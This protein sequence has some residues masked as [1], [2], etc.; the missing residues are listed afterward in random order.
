MWPDTPRRSGPPSVV[1]ILEPRGRRLLISGLLA[2]VPLVFL[3]VLV[4]RSTVDVPV[5]DEWEIVPRL[6]KLHNGT[7]SYLDLWGQHNEH[8]PLFGIALVM[9]LVS[10][11]HW[12]VGAE[13]AANLIVGAL[14][15]AVFAGVVAAAWPEDLRLPLWLLPA[16]SIFVFSPSQYENWLW[17]WQ[18]TILLNVLA[19]VAGLALLSRLDGRWIRLAGAL[20]CGIVATYTFAAGLV[21]WVSGLAVWV[22]DARKARKPA[23]IA[24]WIA[25][26]GLTI[27]SYFY[28]YHANP[29]HPRIEA[30][31]E[32]L[33]AFRLY[34]LYVVK[35]TG[36]AVALYSPDHV[37]LAG[38]A[39][40]VLFAWL[41]FVNRRLAGRPIFTF[42]ILVGLHCLGVAAMT[43]L[44][45]SGFGA[46]QG[47]ASRYV[48]ISTPLWLAVV[49][50]AA[51][52]LSPEG[53]RR[54]ASW[55]FDKVLVAAAAVAIGLSTLVNAQDGTRLSA[56]R[57]ERLEPAR[58]ALINGVG[59]QELVKLYPDVAEVRRRRGLLIE[60]HMSV[61]RSTRAQ[62]DSSTENR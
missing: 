40:V 30:N 44:G 61:F 15:F 13:I 56:E 43:G 60:W 39:A 33:E 28:D 18:V 45:R 4:W 27:A 46:D 26:A 10:A 16:L 59:D 49:V 54:G 29:G 23:Q 9:T 2:L 42:A 6:E 36:A 22:L 5:W 12:S 53:G 51:L 55:T 34:L 62:R 32:S 24:A 17:G 19:V 7:F 35:Y 14:V 1:A 47:L 8:R 37:A 48:T 25:V 50:L 31:F 38:E 20:L 11:T 41:A 57:H 58:R 21:Y 3:A 52:R